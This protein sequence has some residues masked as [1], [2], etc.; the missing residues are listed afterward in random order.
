MVTRAPP[1]TS[2]SL[3]IRPAGPPPAIATSG[4]LAPG[5]SALSE[6]PRSHA[7]FLL[8]ATMNRERRD[9]RTRRQSFCP[10]DADR[11]HGDSNEG[12]K[13]ERKHCKQL[14]WLGRGGVGRAREHG[15]SPRIRGRGVVAKLYLDTGRGSSG[16]GGS[17]W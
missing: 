6:R 3:A 4:L 5:M 10:R 9:L 2:T 15:K 1:C 7:S 11:H 12:G 14:D 17:G 13:R 8:A 16:P